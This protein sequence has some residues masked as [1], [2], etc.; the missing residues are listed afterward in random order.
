M[1]NS[2]WRKRPEPCEVQGCPALNVVQGGLKNKTAKWGK[3]SP[4]YGV[5]RGARQRAHK[6]C[7]WGS[8]VEKRDCELK[9]GNYRPNPFVFLSFMI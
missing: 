3:Y 5:C 6:R 8:G 1:R 9:S 2:E 4:E 7:G